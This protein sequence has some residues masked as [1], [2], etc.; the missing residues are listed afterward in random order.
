MTQNKNSSLLDGYTEPEMQGSAFSEAHPFVSSLPEA[1]KQFALRATKSYPDFAKGLNDAVALGGDVMKRTYNNVS[2][3]DKYKALSKYTFTGNLLDKM[4]QNSDKI[5]DFGRNNAQFWQNASDKIP[6]NP[7]FQGLNGLKNKSTFIPTLMGEVG[8]QATNLV[9][10]SGGAAGGAGLASKLGIGGLGQGALITAGTAIPNLA[11]EG[12]YLDKIEAF[13]SVYGRVPT[14]EELNN[15]QN[16]ALGEKTVNTALETLSDRI[17]FNKLFPKG[18]GAKGIKNILKNAGEQA[19]TEAV[20]EGMQEGV[21]IGAEKLLGINQGNNAE[22]LAESAILG[23]LTGGVIGGAATSVSQPYNTQFVENQTAV[24]PSQ[25]VKDVSAKVFSG[26]K[27]LYNSAVKTVDNALNS[28]TAFDNLKSLSADKRFTPAISPEIEQIAPNIAKKAKAKKSRKKVSSK[29]APSISADMPVE[30]KGILPNNGL[31]NDDINN[32]IMKFEG[33]E[34]VEPSDIKGQYKAYYKGGG[35]SYVS[36]DVIKKVANLPVNNELTIPDFDSAALIKSTKDGDYTLEFRKNLTGKEIDN[37]LPDRVASKTF[38]DFRSAY[39]FIQENNIRINNQD[40]YTSEMNMLNTFKKAEKVAPNIIK[41]RIRK[42]KE[43]VDNSLNSS[44]DDYIGKKFFVGEKEDEITGYVPKYDRYIGKNPEGRTSGAI[45]YTKEDI[46]KYIKG[47]DFEADKAKRE[48]K[49]QE[50]AEKKQKEAEQKVSEETE[51]NNDNGF[52]NGKSSLQKG[53]ILKTLNKEVLY[54]EINNGQPTTSKKAIEELVSKG[55]VPEEKTFTKTY[56]KNGER[57]ERQTN[58]LVMRNKEGAFFEVNKTEYDYAKYLSDKGSNGN[59]DGRSVNEELETTE[60][61]SIN[62]ITEKIKIAVNKDYAAF[63]KSINEG[64]TIKELS[65]TNSLFKHLAEDLKDVEDYIIAKMPDNSTSKIKGQHHKNHKVIMLN[66]DV[67]G[68]DV[69]KFTETLMHEVQHAKQTKKYQQILSKKANGENL[70]ED[71]KAYIAKYHHCRK[72]NKERQE[73]YKKHKKVIDDIMRKVRG[74]DEVSKQ[75]YINNLKPLTKYTINKYYDLYYKYYDT[76]FEVEARQA[77][78]KY[79]ER[80]SC[81]GQQKTRLENS[82]R[83]RGQRDVRTGPWG[84]IEED[85][86]GRSGSG[87]NETYRG[88]QEAEEVADNDNSPSELEARKA[89]VFYAERLAHE[90]ETFENGNSRV[91]RSVDKFETGFGQRSMGARP[92]SSL[93]DYQKTQRRIKEAEDSADFGIGLSGLRRVTNKNSDTSTIKDFDID[94]VSE[95][96]PKVKNPSGDLKHFAKKVF[97]PISSRLDDINPVLK[98]AIRKFELNS[99]LAEN[100]SAEIVKPFFDKLS[101]MPEADYAK[102]DLALKNGR[103][104]IIEALNEKYSLE[105]EYNNIRSL[106]DKIRDDALDAGMDVGLIEDYFPRKVINPSAIIEEYSKSSYIR[107]LLKEVDPKN[108]L[109]DEEKLAKVNAA[110][111]G[112]NNAIN[113]TSS[114][115]KG[116][117]INRI[118]KDL[119]RHYKDSKIALADYITSMN[120]AIQVRKFFG[121]GDNIDESIGAYT[122][123]LTESGLITPSDEVE[124][125]QILKARFNQRGV[126]GILS[127]IKNSGYIFT[128]GNPLSAVTQIGDFAF[129]LYKNGVF[130]TMTG[131]T[132]AIGTDK[133]SKQDLGIDKIAQEFES[134]SKTSKLVDKIF[135]VVGLNKIDALGKETFINASFN[136]LKRQAE[137]STKNPN[138]V[139]SIKFNNYLKSI[140]GNQAKIVKL[141]LSKDVISDDVKYLLF[142]EISDFQPISLSEMP[143]VYLTSGN[144]RIFYMLKTYSIKLVDVFRNEAFKQMK[145]DQKQGLQNLIKLGFYVMALGVGADSLKDLFMGREINLDDTLTDNL[146]KLALFS[147]YQADRSRT[148]G[149]GKTVLTSILPP[150]NVLDDLWKDVFDKKFKSGDKP[151]SSLRTIRNIP[152]GGKLYYWWFGAGKEVKEKEFKNNRKKEFLKAYKSNNQKI[153]DIAA[154]KML[155][156][157]SSY[158]DVIK[159]KNNVKNSYLKTYKEQYVTALEK[160]DANAVKKIQKQMENKNIPVI[161][162]REIYAKAVQQYFK[163]RAN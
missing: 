150:T 76:P 71:D 139:E 63:K 6:I 146:L 161:D 148:E 115:V 4:L 121:K 100:K 39:D 119:N 158:K 90:K 123:E 140:F 117:K 54:K 143:E 152:V 111:K 38:K 112:H 19:I 92:W 87:T 56:K 102:Y 73:F 86:E 27:E 108:V 21:S 13:K 47:V 97:T 147:R 149:I 159:M 53:K 101:K 31:S 136:R 30:D 68:D 10:A 15:I 7:S 55:Y 70:S 142:S 160:Q 134:D 25:A 98:H 49:K 95:I 96:L 46:D 129:T 89:G 85:Y 107:N 41:K 88:K 91:Q 64:K 12:Q 151:L 75:K 79:A 114:F 144:G 156:K 82:I 37:F 104:D 24:N 93:T 36:S 163:K 44:K 99:A 138:T 35:S 103:T 116:R 22:R 72:A 17:L 9:M 3:N 51:Y 67:I 69:K 8:G 14:T 57:F 131:L 120:N 48:A 94:D 135:S 81:N 60:D 32:Y 137:E 122:K 162:R 29:V 153:S 157:G 26:G 59:I 5:S 1:G 132:K 40:S 127:D 74:F 155:K 105:D 128:M 84:G 23:G 124:V 65:E 145:T 130:D 34:K 50:F 18:T 133:I 109:S 58:K 42:T 43:K 125:K 2:D 61:F 45:L 77:G 78:V 11:Q 20:T 33:L 106:L 154:Y 28:P 118:T 110:L 16:T 83:L 113:A 80:I 126:S 62:D 66:M 52:T 141:D